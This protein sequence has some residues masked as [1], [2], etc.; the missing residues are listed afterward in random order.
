MNDP[1]P[2]D[3]TTTDGM[4]DWVRQRIKTGPDPKH[5]AQSI[6]ALDEKMK[7]AITKDGLGGEHAFS[8]FTDTMLP[9]TR[10]FGHPSSLSFVAS[11][12]SK[13]SLHSHIS[14]LLTRPVMDRRDVRR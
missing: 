2:F 11:A 12:P 8:L 3:Q 13:A 10:P 14:C 1:F 6:S 7:G 5:G 9:A 4:L